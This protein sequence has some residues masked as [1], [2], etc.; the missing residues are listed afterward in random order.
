MDEIVMDKLSDRVSKL[1]ARCQELER[2]NRELID[3]NQQLLAE[4]NINS[5]MHQHIGNTLSQLVKQISSIE[6]TE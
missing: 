3:S 4:R 1:I 5:Q 2:L 6:D